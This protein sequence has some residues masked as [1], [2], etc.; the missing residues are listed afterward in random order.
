[1]LVPKGSNINAGKERGIYLSHVLLAFDIISDVAQLLL[2]HANSLEVGGVI[3][4]VSSKKK[5]F[6]EV[7]GDVSTGNVQT[8]RQVGQSE[9]FVNRT[10]V[11]HAVTRIDHDASQETCCG[12]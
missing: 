8:P 1:M 4:G 5:Q 6:D 12:L 3:E 9:A 11:S 2:H 10:D 7:S